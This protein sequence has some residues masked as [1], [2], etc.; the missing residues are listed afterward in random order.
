M[1]V[2]NRLRRLFASTLRELPSVEAYKL[3]AQNYP[4]DAHNTLMQ[5]EQEAMLQ[6]IPDLRGKRVL[7]LACGTGRYG[8]IAHENEA[9]YVAGLDNSIDML[10]QAVLD[11]LAL[12]TTTAIPFANETFNTVLC[13]LA[14]G[15]LPT[16]N[17]SLSEISR[18]LAPKGVAIISDFHPFQALAGAQR[19]FTVDG[20]TFAVEHYPHL[21]SDYLNMAATNNLTITGV[22]EPTYNGKPVVFVLRLEKQY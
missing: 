6:L 5:L 15:H 20:G 13:G 14:L 17:P 8:R 22:S 11:N 9:V 16:L 1:T 3:W 19:T 12:A 2:F 21:Y 4:A 7:D 10:K 18:V